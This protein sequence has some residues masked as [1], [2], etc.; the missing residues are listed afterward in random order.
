M[1]L[2]IHG[3]NELQK[4]NIL[5]KKKYIYMVIFFIQEVGIFFKFLPKTLTGHLIVYSPR[6]NFP[7]STHNIRFHGEK[8]KYSSGYLFLSIVSKQFTWNVKPYFL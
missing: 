7:V 1:T 3:V 8:E 5:K 2:C 4:I 6:Q